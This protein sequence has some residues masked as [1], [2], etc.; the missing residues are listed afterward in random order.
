MKV[1]SGQGAEE[2][3][4]LDLA[5]GAQIHML[6]LALESVAFSSS[7][8]S[9][10]WHQLSPENI[11][12]EI[13]SFKGLFRSLFSK[14]LG[15]CFRGWCSARLLSAFTEQGALKSAFHTRG[16]VTTLRIFPVT[17]PPHRC[18]IQPRVFLPFLQR[19]CKKSWSAQI[20]AK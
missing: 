4:Y 6:V 7:C 8:P 1:C 2:L 5:G 11:Q 9:L 12:E 17:V 14:T 3:G 20:L 10:P 19:V 18:F 13:C 16:L 15:N